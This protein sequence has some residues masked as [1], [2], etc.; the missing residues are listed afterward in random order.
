MSKETLH[1]AELFQP[2]GFA[3]EPKAMKFYELTDFNVPLSPETITKLVPS[4]SDK[5]SKIGD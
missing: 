2:N 4:L 5:D 1:Y 3:N